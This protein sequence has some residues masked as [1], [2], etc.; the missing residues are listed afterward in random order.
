[1]LY[2]AL[3]QKL[4][5]SELTFSPQMQDVMQRV[6]E[7]GLH[8]V[9]APLYDLPDMT[10]KTAVHSLGISMLQQHYKYQKIASGLESYAIVNGEKTAAPG[11]YK[12]VLGKLTAPFRSAPSTIPPASSTAHVGELADL[13]EPTKQMRKVPQALGVANPN[14]NPNA[15]NPHAADS[16]VLGAIGRMD[17]IKSVAQQ[18]P[19][20]QAEREMFKVKYPPIADTVRPPAM[21]P[22]TRRP[23][24]PAEQAAAQ[25]RK[26]LGYPGTQ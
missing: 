20:A 14:Y 5:S 13:L 19:A 2:D 21:N 10:L 6:R 7:T 24:V 16:R 1:M 17:Q 15:V 3:M 22:L 9:A 11:D 12:R 4:G 18:L 8:K 26:R 23:S 25:G